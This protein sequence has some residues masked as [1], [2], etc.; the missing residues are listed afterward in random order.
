MA[1]DG[2]IYSN[3]YKSAIETSRLAVDDLKEFWRSS[4]LNENNIGELELCVVELL[5][6]TFEHAYDGKDGQLIE[7]VSRCNESKVLVDISHFG[8]SMSQEE[9]HSVLEAD[10]IAPDPNDPETWVTSGRG[11]MILAALLDEIE[12]T[13]EGDKSTFTLIKRVQREL[14]PYR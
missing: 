3:T 2:E 8:S 10:F 6:N 9:F 1:M 13:Q 11:F 7:V 4:L 5:N 12:L 14:S